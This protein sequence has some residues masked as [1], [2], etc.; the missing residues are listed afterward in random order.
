M[1]STSLLAATLAVFAAVS[2]CTYRNEDL[3]R[4][5]DPYWFVGAFF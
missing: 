4:V 3:N 1:R 5:V 2:A